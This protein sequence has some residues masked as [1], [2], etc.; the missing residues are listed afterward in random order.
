MIVC[1]LYLLPQRMLLLYQFVVITENSFGCTHGIVFS[2][3]LLP[4]IIRLFENQCSPFFT[5]NIAHF[6]TIT[7]VTGGF[8][9]SC[10]VYQI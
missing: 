4:L 6:S 3:L 1:H 9:K 2:R 8:I 7:I 10:R 5:D